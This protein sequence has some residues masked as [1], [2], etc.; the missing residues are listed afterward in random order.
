MSSL[1]VT[2]GATYEGVGFT[3]VD[4]LIV[5][6]GSDPELNPGIAS[7]LR[8]SS[9]L[10]YRPEDRNDLLRSVKFESKKKPL[11]F[12]GD[13]G[14]DIPNSISQRNMSSYDTGE[15]SDDDLVVT[16]NSKN[17]EGGDSL[18]HKDA[19]DADIGNVDGGFDGGDLL[20][21]F[22]GGGEGSDDEFEGGA[23]GEYF[24]W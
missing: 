24:S 9:G 13:G 19:P 16:P 2:G 3:N 1:V 22:E 23:V 7:L 10:G 18:T 5:E 14:L 20:F 11:T 21:K 15:Y 17:M 6:T 12:R 4:S 8:P